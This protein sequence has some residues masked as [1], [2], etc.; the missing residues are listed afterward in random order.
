MFS[1][2]SKNS[3]NHEKKTCLSSGDRL[4][5]SIVSVSSPPGVLNFGGVLQGVG[6]TAMSGRVALGMIGGPR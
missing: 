5:Q 1:N 2:L 6:G 4:A 3:S